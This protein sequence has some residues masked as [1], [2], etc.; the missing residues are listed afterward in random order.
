MV[1]AEITRELGT[2]ADGKRRFIYFVSV[3]G[4]PDGERY[5]SPRKARK[6]AAERLKYCSHSCEIVELWSD[7]KVYRATSGG[8]PLLVREKDKSV[9]ETRTKICLACNGEKPALQINGFGECRACVEN[10]IHA[11]RKASGIQFDNGHEAEAAID[12]VVASFP[13]VFGL[14]QRS[15]MFKIGRERCS[16]HEGSVRLVILT[17]Q[18]DGAW[19]YFETDSTAELQRNIVRIER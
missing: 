6:A 4:T 18:N 7:G 15:G 17:L 1:R 2:G 3:Q 8:Q 12:A 16:V 19:V 11:Q 10:R 5:E 13:A 9:K 14:A